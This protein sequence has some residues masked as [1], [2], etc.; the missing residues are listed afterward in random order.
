M[1][2]KTVRCCLLYYYYCHSFRQLYKM[3]NRTLEKF[4]ELLLQ[5]G[6]FKTDQFEYQWY[7][8]QLCLVNGVS[9]TQPEEVN[10]RFE[11]IW[12]EVQK[13][14]VQKKQKSE[15]EKVIQFRLKSLLSLPF[16]EEKEKKHNYMKCLVNFLQSPSLV[17]VTEEEDDHVLHFKSRE[18]LFHRLKKHCNIYTEASLKKLEQRAA[19]RLLP[20]RPDY[21]LLGRCHFSYFT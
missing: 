9:G 14:T 3:D 18:A 15:V 5:D 20:G 13:E 10:E 17:A 6:K 2:S 16:I 1:F 4:D 19:F 12:S 11:E 7:F 21:K 8:E